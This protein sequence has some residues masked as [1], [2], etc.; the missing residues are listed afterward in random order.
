MENE[1]NSNSSSGS[2]EESEYSDIDSDRP[3]LL[4]INKKIDK[5]NR[6]KNL[7]LLEKK[8]NRNKNL[9]DI[10]YDANKKT[11]ED[12]FIPNLEEL[13]DFLKNCKIEEIKFE[14]LEKIPKEKIFDPNLFIEEN[15]GK[16]EIDKN[17]LKH[18]FSIEDL[19]FEFD[20]KEKNDLK[21]EKLEKDLIY[22]TIYED[23]L[24]LNK[25][26]QE[27]GLKKQKNDIHELIEKIKKMEIEDIKKSLEGKANTKLNIVFDLDNTCVFSLPQNI[28]N[29]NNIK[30]K[31]SHKD[32][33]LI[34][35]QL[36][37]RIMITIFILRK[38]LE[39]FFNFTKSFCNF[40]IST[41]GFESYGL[42]IK[43]ILETKFKINFSGFKGRLYE[44][45]KVKY[46]NDV[47]LDAKD[48]L[49]FDDKPVVWKRDLQ[50]VIISKL[51]TDRE[52]NL[53]CKDEFLQ[54]NINLFLM[55]YG[56]FFYYKSSVNNWQEQNL[57]EEITCPF[58]DFRGRNCFSG[59][60]LESTKYQ[61]IFMKEIIKI[62]YY[63]V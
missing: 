52:I 55:D 14:E 3:N 36:K 58:Y 9:N 24:N 45:E 22:K 35:F 61:F 48:T 1:E 7:S 15:Y 16:K 13:N 34:R 40:Y 11:I 44:K 42:K 37:D 21:N 4:Q 39:D 51:F 20:F 30:K 33:N 2:E 28:N 49:I 47:K 17:E 29:I 56:P 50:N 63:L 62:I 19:G 26:L 5:M 59:E 38:G 43:E 41:L 23:K 8:R 60:Y 6:E 27:K 57:K 12:S 53:L 46:L 31:Y 18:S 10:I 25:I 54:K 32:F